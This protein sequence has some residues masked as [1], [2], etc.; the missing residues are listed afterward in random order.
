[1]KLLLVIDQFF[2]LENSPPPGSPSGALLRLHPDHRASLNPKL[3]FRASDS[4][5]SPDVTGGEYKARERIHRGMADPRLLAIPASWGRV[6]DPNPNWDQLL[7]ISSALRLG[8]P[9]Y[10]PLYHEC[11]PGHKGHADLA[12]SPPSFPI[13]GTVSYDTCNI[14]QGLRSLPHLREHL[15]ARADDNHAAPVLASDW[16]RS[17]NLSAG[18]HARMSS[19][20]KVPRLPSN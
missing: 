8:N 15:K 5:G 11:R 12:S 2:Y 10:W 14:G 1:M 13:I 3:S 17:S 19:P 7:G 18:L 20:G 16:V 6:A 9:L 4:P